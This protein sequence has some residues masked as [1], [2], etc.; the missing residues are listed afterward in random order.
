MLRAQL[1][2]MLS[3]FLGTYIP[4]NTYMRFPQAALGS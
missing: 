3:F 1:L 2:Y 4:V